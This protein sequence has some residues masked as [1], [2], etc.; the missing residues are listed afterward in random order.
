MN[1]P[2]LTET[3]RMAGVKIGVAEPL[4]GR[5]GAKFALVQMMRLLLGYN[6]N[7]ERNNQPLRL[8]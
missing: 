8:L 3:D 1:L 4:R 7:Y 6:G 5:I 2:E